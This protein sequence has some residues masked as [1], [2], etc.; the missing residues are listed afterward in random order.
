MVVALIAARMGS[1]RFPGKTL[2]N[3]YGKPMIERMLER[4]RFSK[5]IDQVVLATTIN[6]EDD[7]LEEWSNKMNILCYRGSSDDVLG[8][9]KGAVDEFKPDTIVELLG[10][11]PIVDSGI[12]DSAVKK[13]NDNNY[14]YLATVTNEYKLAKDSLKKFP[15]GVR[16]QVFSPET[17]IKCYNLANE[18]KHREHATSYIAD[19]PEIFNTGFL[20]ADN[21]FLPCNRPDLTF[22][23]NHRENL[24]MINAIF[25]E[26]Y[27]D[28]DNFTLESAIRAFESN[29]KL[30][31][32]MGNK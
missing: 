21:Q 16:V 7:P 27:E 26:C 15:I 14:D 6:K 1:S 31:I 22:A 30:N 18:Y 25:D 8:R 20:E 2:S 11:N 24:E 32:L 3:L 19:N 13:Y 23:V 5:S 12:I 17:I 9:I 10:D 28:N 4:V 29:P